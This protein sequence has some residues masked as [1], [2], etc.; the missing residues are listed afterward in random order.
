MIAKEKK[1]WSSLLEALQ[2]GCVIED[3]RICLYYDQRVKAM[4]ERLPLEPNFNIRHWNEQLRIAYSVNK[5]VK[6][7]PIFV[8]LNQGVHIITRDNYF[9]YKN[10]EMAQFIK[11]CRKKDG[12]YNWE[13]HTIWDAMEA[14]EAE[15]KREEK[16]AAIERRYDEIIKEFEEA[17]DWKDGED[18]DDEEAMQST[19][20]EFA[21][22]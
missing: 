20:T 21:Y 18:L 19:D 2:R 6:P 10:H 7:Y 11:S 22:P 14:A 1:I 5:E 8:R 15:E 16:E 12:I 3:E 17:I 9:A 4:V 13:K